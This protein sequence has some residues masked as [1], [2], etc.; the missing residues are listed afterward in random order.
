MTDA[1]LL[2]GW[3]GFKT[4]AK[5]NAASPPDPSSVWHRVSSVVAQTLTDLIL[6][7]C[8][9]VPR[10]LYGVH[11]D[12]HTLIVGI[13]SNGNDLVLQG[14]NYRGVIPGLVESCLKVHRLENPDCLVGVLDVKSG[15]MD[16]S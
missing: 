5:I 16:W 13:D 15:Q 14:F 11:S 10:D 4:M 12:D 1:R 6:N 7:W 9:P 8:L 3:A 2:R